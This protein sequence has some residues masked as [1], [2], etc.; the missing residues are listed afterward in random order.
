MPI[1]ILKPTEKC[2]C[3]CGC[4]ADVRSARIHCPHRPKDEPAVSEAKAGITP[5]EARV[6]LEKRA[7]KPTTITDIV[8]LTGWLGVDE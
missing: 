8:P 3:G 6:L 4:P 7:T 5:E 2:T 1:C